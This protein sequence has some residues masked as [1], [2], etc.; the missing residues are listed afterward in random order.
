MQR[1]KTRDC[2]ENAAPKLQDWKTEEKACMESQTVLH[3]VVVS[4]VYSISM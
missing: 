2:M 4:L 1:W 3:N